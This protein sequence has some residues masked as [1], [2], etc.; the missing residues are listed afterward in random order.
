VRW[1]PESLD[2]GELPARF[3]S[4]LSWL[5]TGASRS[6]P[7]GTFN[8]YT[9]RANHVDRDLIEEIAKRRFASATSVTHFEIYG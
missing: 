4:E 6:S 9:E 2:L 7:H 8:R 1:R 3:L 5:L